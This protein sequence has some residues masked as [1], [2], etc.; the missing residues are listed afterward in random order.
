MKWVG[1][2]L[3]WKFPLYPPFCSF[4]LSIS[5]THLPTFVDLL[6]GQDSSADLSLTMISPTM[7]L[8][9]PILLQVLGVNA[10]GFA[11]ILLRDIVLPRS[12]AGALV[13]HAF[14]IFDGTPTVEA[15]ALP[16]ACSFVLGAIDYCS[17]VS[18]GWLTAPPKTQATCLCYSSASWAPS[19]FDNSVS[20]CTLCLVL[21]TTCFC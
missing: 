4:F 3:R 5:G 14:G 16:S 12:P 18:P 19:I 13:G 21:E 10:A 9:L 8:A 7:L 15:R 2:G 17:S 11:D 6:Q 20:S 1:P